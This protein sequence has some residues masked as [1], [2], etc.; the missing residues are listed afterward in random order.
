MYGQDL[1]SRGM[2]EKRI[3]DHQFSH[4]PFRDDHKIGQSSDDHDG[5]AVLH[6]SRQNVPCWEG[7]CVTTGPDKDRFAALRPLY[8]LRCVN[9]GFDVLAV[10][11]HRVHLYLGKCTTFGCNS[12]R[13]RKRLTL[14]SWSGDDSRKAENIP[15]NGGLE[16]CECRVRGK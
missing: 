16:E 5:D 15:E 13:R 7:T 9:C 12:V 6:H 8:V 10:E 3:F 11:I 4:L 2:R 14:T 1:R